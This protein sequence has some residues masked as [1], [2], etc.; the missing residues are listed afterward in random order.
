MIK[1]CATPTSPSGGPRDEEGP[2]ITNVQP[3]SGTVNF[4]GREIELSFSEFVE[5]SSLRQAII[6]E[7]DIGLNYSL[8][9]GRKSAAIEFDSQLP[10]TTTIL[11]SIGTE[12]SDTRGNE[13]TEPLRVAVS[14]GPEID[15]GEIVG[16]IL[17]AQTGKGTSGDRVLL[18]REPFDLTRKAD[19]LAQTDTSGTFNFTYLRQGRYKVFWVNDQNRSKIWEQER[20]RAQPFF[21]ETITLEKAGKDTLRTLY[22][23]G[24]DTTMPK[25]Q[26][27]G[28]FSTRRMRLRFSENI[29][30]TDSSR[31]VVN[32]SLGNRYSSSNPLYI[33]PEEQY[34]L[35][36]QNGKDLQATQTYQV[37]AQNF[38]DVAGNVQPMT[39][40][41]FEGTAQED[42]TQQR[43]IRQENS[44]GIY[45]DEPLEIV[46]ARPIS[47]QEVID[48]LSVVEGDSLIENWPDIQ[49]ERNKLLVMP[50]GT[51]PQGLDYEIRV[52]NPSS[53]QR[54]SYTLNA[55]HQAD[56]GGIQ[57]A[58][59]DTADHRPYKLILSTEERGTMLDTTFTD[60]LEVDKLPP[61]QYKATIYSDLND[62]GEWDEGTV[63]PFRAP[64]PYFV[65][66]K[67]PVK[68]AMVSEVEIAFE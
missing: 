58:L 46:Y 18:Y 40:M 7:P 59:A 61:L 6:V 9:W 35:F 45:P 21:R 22:K 5:R 64:E 68:D 29:E 12:L 54:R 25:L 48:S 23:A 3:E 2:K 60:S 27:V 28:L 8:D 20:E 10:D 19:Y 51:W 66:P 1:G 42:T 65:R 50:P 39:T 43:I 32:D 33:L 52:W 53:Q 36:A 55:W 14:T 24:A 16:R 13:M 56:Y 11:V 57:F 15:E 38:M 49:A 37:E 41:Q 34:V 4:E 30:R 17:D 62:N 47:D 31:I 44:D 63:Q 26:G 67:L